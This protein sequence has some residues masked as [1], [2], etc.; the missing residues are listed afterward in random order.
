[1]N[2]ATPETK[3][4]NLKRF[5]E[6]LLYGL[7]GIATRTLY[8]TWRIEKHDPQNILKTHSPW[9]VIFSCWHNRLLFTPLMFPRQFRRNTAGLAS[10][11]RDGEYAAGLLKVYGMKT[12]RGSTSRGGYKALARLKQTIEAGNSVAITPDGPRGPRYE[13][14]PGAVILA[15]KTGAPIVPLA[16]NAPKRWEL[17][18]WDKTQIPKPFSH[19]DLHIG[20]P[21][22][23]TEQD[24]ETDLQTLRQS[25]QKH[26]MSITDDSKSDKPT[27]NY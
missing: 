24:A 25:L 3:Q 18:G 11:S 6:P 23:Y 26:M 10:Y 19:L 16:I 5:T 7:I 22:Y 14:Q 12:V 17:N 15:L 9:P 27:N 20:E 2:K 21:I 8:F 4:A 13:A 1:M